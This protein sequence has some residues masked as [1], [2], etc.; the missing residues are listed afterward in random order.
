MVTDT[1]LVRGDVEKEP[2]VIL[3][4]SLRM[5]ARSNLVAGRAGL[6][7]AAGSAGLAVK[8]AAFFV[9]EG[10]VVDVL[11]EVIFLIPVIVLEEGEGEGAAGEL[12]KEV[13]EGAG[14]GSGR[15]ILVVLTDEEKVEKE[16]EDEV[17]VA[18][19]VSFTL[20][21]LWGA[22]NTGLLETAGVFCPVLPGTE[23]PGTEGGSML[24][25][26]CALGMFRREEKGSAAALVHKPGRLGEVVWEG[27]RKGSLGAVFRV[28]FEPTAPVRKDISLTLST[29]MLS[30]P[31]NNSSKSM[32][33]SIAEFRSSA[34]NSSAVFI[35]DSDGGLVTRDSASG[36]AP[37][38]TPSLVTEG[39]TV[40]VCAD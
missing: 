3:A 28:E 31:A 15:A 24:P 5:A 9:D 39:G 10:V 16:E 33:L 34:F 4:T 25:R 8:R 23:T 38:I 1:V 29:L 12:V 18:A 22:V 6:V 21:T 37:P 27:R 14:K 32:S 20:P 40:G 2:G 35:S 30:P 7:A 19:A 11:V 26:W 36:T 13:S 17:E